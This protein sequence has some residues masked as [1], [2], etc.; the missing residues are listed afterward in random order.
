MT[1]DKQGNFKTKLIT[2][3][4]PIIR[5][6]TLAIHCKFFDNGYIYVLIG[7]LVDRDVNNNFKFNQE[8]EFIPII[9]LISSQ[10]NAPTD[11]ETK[12]S[13]EVKPASSIQDDHHPALLSLVAEELS[14]DVQEIHDFELYVVRS[15][16]RYNDATHFL[17]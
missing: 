9:G 3:A 14:V 6:P 15:H 4:R 10:L 5:I 8:T 17:N 13:G 12:D 11:K 7:L 2:I 16:I 1:A